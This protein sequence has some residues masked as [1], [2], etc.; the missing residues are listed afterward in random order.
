MTNKNKYLED[1]SK[2]LSAEKFRDELNKAANMVKNKEVQKHF[3]DEMVR[4]TW[5]YQKKYGFE[6]S[7][8]KDHEFCNNEADATSSSDDK[9]VTING[10][11]VLIKD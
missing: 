8:R 1:L 11:H 9:W 7:P 2:K 10:N 3:N 4:K 5:K 6:T